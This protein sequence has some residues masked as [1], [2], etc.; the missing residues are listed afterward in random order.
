MAR[1][2]RWLRIAASA[3]LARLPPAKRLFRLSIKDM[4]LPHPLELDVDQVRSICMSLTAN[5]EK[6]SR[7]H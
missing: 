3:N 6:H 5:K 1:A 4:F 2:P 7:E